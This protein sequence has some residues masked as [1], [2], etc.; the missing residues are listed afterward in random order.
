MNHF[1]Y[2]D[3]ELYCEDVPLATIAR[4]VGTPV[5]VYSRATLARHYLVFDQ[6]LSSLDHL[7]C[8]SVKANSNLAVLRLLGNLGAGA[9]IVSGG[10][11]Y[12][13]LRAGGDVRKIVFSGVGKT[14]SE[15]REALRAGILIFNVESRDELVLLDRVAG[16]E[17]VRAPVAFRVNPDVDAETHPYISTGLK[18][19]KF[20]IPMAAAHE[21]YRFARTLSNIDIVGVDCHIGSQLTKTSPFADAIVR[22]NQ[23]IQ[24]LADDGFSIRYLDIGGGLGIPYGKE[25]EPEPPTP[26]DYG[27]TVSA[28]LAPLA[29]LHLTVICEPGR[30]IAGNAGAL[31]TRVLY[32]KSSEAKHF[33]VVD[34]AFND[35]MRP[36]L[37]GSFHPIRPVV[38]RDDRPVHVTDVVGPICESG[39]FLARDRELPE[40]ESGELACVGAAGAYGFAMASNYNTRPRPAEVLVDG[41][42]YAVVRRRETVEQLVDS[43][44]IP[45][46]L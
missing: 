2:R 3:N 1:N 36:A 10:E 38:H 4:E 15:M 20:G 11:L 21:H 26:A 43:E 16:E 37:Y 24:G 28:A 5:Y 23:L 46:F 33:T 27:Q 39:D 13:V 29:D 19:N 32:R 7:I 8:F 42:R 17:G 9:D 18:E 6:A 45:D 44:S 12:R 14:A 22:L 31:V 25:D 35:L 34:A 30:V 41:D 40:M